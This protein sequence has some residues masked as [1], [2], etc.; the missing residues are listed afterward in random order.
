M[1]FGAN[2]TDVGLLRYVCY[3]SVQ[4][5]DGELHWK[6]EDDG[7]RV[8]EKLT[9]RSVFSLCGKL[10]GHF[11]VCSWLRP[12]V[13]FI[14]RR[15]NAVTEQ[16]DDL[17]S[18]EH[19]RT[20]LME[21]TE[22]VHHSDPVRGRWDV[23]GTEAHLWVDAS[24]VAIGVALEVDG[25][26]IEDG[27]WLRGSDATHINMAELDAVVKGLNLTLAWVFERIVRYTDSATVHRWISD[28]LTGKARLRT[29]AA[30]E[31]LIRRRVELVTSL[32]KEYGLQLSVVLVP[33]EQNKADVLTRV[34]QRW[35]RSLAEGSAEE[36]PACGLS[37]ETDENAVNSMIFRVHHDWGHPG[38]RSTLA[39]EPK[40]DQETDTEDR[41]NV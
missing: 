30:S 23:R 9:R 21:V 7:H 5:E 40:R 4:R 29:K 24:S 17:S 16:W 36:V 2:L 1:L 26:V 3:A 39:G 25:S 37:V 19:V 33:S 20:F 12:A 18:C 31:M 15:A 34:P 35:L 28:G 14:K 27:A 22:K 8:P 13:A 32:V 38:V 11:P 41:S 6:R 10:V